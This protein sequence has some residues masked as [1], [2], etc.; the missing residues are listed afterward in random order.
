MNRISSYFGAIVGLFLLVGCGQLQ[1]RAGIRHVC[2]ADANET[3]AM[4]AGESALGE[5]LFVIDKADVEHGYISTQPLAGA[6]FFEFWRSDNVGARNW[7]Q[8][9][10]QSI[11]RTAQL[12]IS[13]RQE[14]VCI[15]CEVKVQRLS[16]PEHEVS[17]S[18]RAY[19]MFSRSSARMQS[20]RLR[21]GQKKHAGWVDLQ[22]DGELAAEILKRIE[23]KLSTSGPAA[24]D[25]IRDE[26]AR[27]APGQA[28]DT[29]RGEDRESL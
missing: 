24:S 11:R 10:L 6:Q 28:G 25:Q 27:G 13:V 12:N 22:S 18:V 7:A 21:P 1:Q 14:K 5:M 4:Q 20:L 19:Q 26:A 9:N 17:S 15:S 8:A 3:A 29:Q 16:M 23:K 2:I